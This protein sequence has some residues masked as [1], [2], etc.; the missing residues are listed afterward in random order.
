MT[1]TCTWHSQAVVDASDSEL[2]YANTL[3]VA[4]ALALTGIDLI[5][6]PE[7]LTAVRQEFDRSLQQRTAI[8]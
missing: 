1:G 6:D 4:K 3:T 5:R 7:L 8:A 2:A